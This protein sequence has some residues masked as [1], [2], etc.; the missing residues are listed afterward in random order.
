MTLQISVVWKKSTQKLKTVITDKWLDDIR[1]KHSIDHIEQITVARYPS[2]FRFTDF[3][4]TAGSCYRVVL[5]TKDPEVTLIG[6]F[7]EGHW[8]WQKITFMN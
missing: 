4:A 1:R 8:I 7:H 2:G 5:A 3:T 6:A